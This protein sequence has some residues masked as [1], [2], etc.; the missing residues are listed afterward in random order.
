MQIAAEPELS[1]ETGKDESSETVN[2]H[3]TKELPT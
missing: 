3:K 2:I 1:N